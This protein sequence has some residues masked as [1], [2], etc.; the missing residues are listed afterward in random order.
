MPFTDDDLKRAKE[1][2]TDRDYDYMV[3]TLLARLESAE[4]EREQLRVRL[5]AAEKCIDHN[6]PTDP[7]YIAWRK[8]C[9]K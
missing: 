2:W 1:T 8:E 6:V 3:D 9:G 4:R 5:E 7:D